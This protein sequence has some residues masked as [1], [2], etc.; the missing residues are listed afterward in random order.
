M[1]WDWGEILSASPHPQYGRRTRLRNGQT[2]VFSRL[3]L[4]VCN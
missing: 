1:S 3:S 2:K 4:R